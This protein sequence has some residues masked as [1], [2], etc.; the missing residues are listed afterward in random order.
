MEQELQVIRLV[1]NKTSPVIIVAI[2]ITIPY[3]HQREISP[4]PSLDKLGSV[5]VEYILKKFTILGV[6]NRF[7]SST[8]FLSKTIL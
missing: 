6:K 8:C 1:K 3:I 2:S 7:C 5:V 4:L